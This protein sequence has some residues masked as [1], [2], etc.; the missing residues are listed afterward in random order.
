M[1]DKIAVSKQDLKALDSDAAETVSSDDLK[2][3]DNGEAAEAPQEDP[4]TISRFMG[5]AKQAVGPAIRQ[6]M[7][8]VI[9]A[10]I[11]AANT[12]KVARPALEMG[13]AALGGMAGG[14]AGSVAGPVGS[15]VGGLAGETVGY[16]AGSQAAQALENKQKGVPNTTE[17]LKSLPKQLGEGA[18]YGAM[19]LGGGLAL[20]GA[21][22]VLEPYAPAILEKIAK[23][24]IS[25]PK[26]LRDKVIA[27]SLKYNIPWTK[28]GLDKVEGI[29]LI[30]ISSIEPNLL[31]DE[32]LDHWLSSDKICK[33]FHIPL[34]SGSDL[35]D[36]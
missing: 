13:G 6:S 25:V 36:A 8:P 29:E 23:I 4:N 2:A 21:S 7:G 3:L 12:P 35:Y 15:V 1:A 16:A 22:K 32:L 34:Q 27:T 33:H 14:A 5:K 17:N 11:S 31:S 26:S 10:G 19:G 24:P 20:K 18:I 30:R 28:A 9:N